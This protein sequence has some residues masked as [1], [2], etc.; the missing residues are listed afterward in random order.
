ME[1]LSKFLL[2]ALKFLLEECIDLS[3]RYFWLCHVTTVSVYFA[4]GNVINNSAQLSR[5][6]RTIIEFTGESLGKISTLRPFSHRANVS[7]LS[8]SLINTSIY[9]ELSILKILISFNSLLVKIWNSARRIFSGTIRKLI[10]RF[11]LLPNKK[12]KKFL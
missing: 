2:D 3:P 1:N 6:E 11:I 4:V 7:S 8:D 12:K 5:D 10:T 9:P